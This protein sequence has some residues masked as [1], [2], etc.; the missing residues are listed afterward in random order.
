MRR[1]DK[2]SM[3]SVVIRVRYTCGTFV[4]TGGGKRASCTASEHSAAWALAS[5]LFDDQFTLKE[6]G[7]GAG[8]FYR[9]TA[10]EGV[11]K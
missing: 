3:D 10:A 5:K 2:Q 9:A 7:R 1:A 4:A 6:C 11:A 8:R